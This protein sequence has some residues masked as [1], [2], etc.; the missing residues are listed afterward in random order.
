[1]IGGM[2]G[3]V[4]VMLCRP[5]NLPEEQRERARCSKIMVVFLMVFILLLAAFMMAT[6][7]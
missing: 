1:M 5:D 2:I 3:I 6:A 7:F 4:F